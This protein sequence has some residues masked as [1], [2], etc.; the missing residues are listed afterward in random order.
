MAHGRR[1]DC[2]CHGSAGRRPWPLA[3]PAPPSRSPVGG[4]PRWPQRSA[5]RA[6]ALA[7]LL[8]TTT[9]TCLTDIVAR[10]ASASLAAAVPGVGATGRALAA[11]RGLVAES[12]EEAVD[13]AVGLVLTEKE[14]EDSAIVSVFSA[15]F[16]PCVDSVSGLARGAAVRSTTAH[17]N[18]RALRAQS[19]PS[20]AD[21]SH[22]ITLIGGARRIDR[23]WICTNTCVG[24]ASVGYFDA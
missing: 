19:H 5:A 11:R 20:L 21:C 10:M 7:Q 22:E 18:G 13:E 3:A 4:R 16:S 1:A 23:K 15:S 6:T 14:A 9:Q 24:V 12:D 17:P 8:P 2:R